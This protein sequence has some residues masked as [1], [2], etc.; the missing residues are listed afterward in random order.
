M[1]PVKRTT[2]MFEVGEI[3]AR[4]GSRS[5]VSDGVKS[6]GAEFCSADADGAASTGRDL[7]SAANVSRIARVDGNF[8]GLS[9]IGRDGAGTASTVAIGFFRGETSVD[10]RAGAFS[11]RS[12]DVFVSVGHHDNGDFV[13]WLISGDAGLLLGTS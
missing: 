2:R 12:D 3:T 5:T 10:G 13:G 4:C 8:A 6:D 9:T 11:A 1:S 7:L